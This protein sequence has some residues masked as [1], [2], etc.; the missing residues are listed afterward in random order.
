MKSSIH[1]KYYSC[2]SVWKDR[3]HKQT[4]KEKAA[5]RLDCF[6][7]ITYIY[8]QILKPDDLGLLTQRE[9]E[10]SM[11]SKYATYG[12][13]ALYGVRIVFS[14]FARGMFPYFRDWIK[15][16]FLGI[17]GGLAFGLIAEKVACETYYNQV[18]ISLA[19][20]YNFTPEEV[21]DL[22]RKLNEYY[23]ERER[24]DD[25]ARAD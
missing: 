9:K 11:I 10:L 23:I 20:K 25:L 5:E 8:P 7:T 4:Q 21:T 1:A 6:L 2:M 13:F 15:H 22:Q 12:F 3:T 24:Q 17:G 18:L 14:V 19:D 16:G